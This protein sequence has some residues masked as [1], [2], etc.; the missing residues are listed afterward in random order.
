MGLV[1]LAVHCRLAQGDRDDQAPPHHRSPRRINEVKAD[2][3][4]TC[5]LAA[6]SPAGHC[7]V[8]R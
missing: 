4:M 8:Y 7:A 2:L 1:E 6:P 5:F 3:N